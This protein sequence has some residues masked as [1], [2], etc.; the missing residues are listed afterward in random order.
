MNHAKPIISVL[1]EQSFS[2]RLGGAILVVI[3]PDALH[4]DEGGG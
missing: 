1:P 2:D 3:T 4:A